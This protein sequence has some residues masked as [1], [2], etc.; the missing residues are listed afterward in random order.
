MSERILKS[1]SNYSLKRLGSKLFKAFLT[2]GGDNYL[3]LNFINE[4]TEQHYSV[5]VKPTDKITQGHKNIMLET[6]IAELENQW[7]S[8]EDRLPDELQSVLSFSSYEGVFQSI[9][10]AGNFKKTLVV[11]EHLNV[12]LWMPLP[13]PPN[14]ALKELDK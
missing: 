9:Y 8:V 5:T 13:Q 3:E 10:R 2:D 1:M 4:K 11:W 7:I 14:E 12:T 6:K